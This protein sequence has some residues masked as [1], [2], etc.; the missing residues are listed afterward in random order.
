MDLGTKL[1]GSNFFFN[2][3]LCAVRGRPELSPVGIVFGRLRL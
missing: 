2:L 1:I 3:S